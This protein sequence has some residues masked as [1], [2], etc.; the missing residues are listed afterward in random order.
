MKNTDYS[1]FAN[2]GDL[3]CYNL[4]ELT[5][6]VSNMTLNV[7]EGNLYKEAEWSN[8]YTSICIRFHA[9]GTFDQLIKEVW[10]K[11]KLEIVYN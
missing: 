8:D 1:P 7:R 9:D 2:V 11:E 6:I 10:K 3:R 5:N 4:E